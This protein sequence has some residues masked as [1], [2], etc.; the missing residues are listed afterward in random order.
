MRNQTSFFFMSTPSLT[1]PSRLLAK[2]LSTFWLRG[3]RGEEL[4]PSDKILVIVYQLSNCEDPGGEEVSPAA[5]YV[6]LR[7]PFLVGGSLIFIFNLAIIRQDSSL[8]VVLLHIIRKILA[9]SLGVLVVRWSI[10]F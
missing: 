9:S 6:P 2:R 10:I 7:Q 3:P 1:T 4:S 8:V 5:N